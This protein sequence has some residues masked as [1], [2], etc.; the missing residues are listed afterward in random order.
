[1][2]L[3]LREPFEDVDPVIDIAIDNGRCLALLVH[4]RLLAVVPSPL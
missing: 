1:V 4:R 2:A 3:R